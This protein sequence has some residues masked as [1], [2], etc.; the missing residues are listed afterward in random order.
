[1]LAICPRRSAI[2]VSVKS[3]LG[4]AQSN[5]LRRTNTIKS[6]TYNQLGRSQHPKFIRRSAV[7][8]YS[9]GLG[10]PRRGMLQKR[11]CKPEQVV[12]TE[13]AR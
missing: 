9:A 6:N 13:P 1:V 2:S 7:G 4:K 11:R 12:V 10:V 5:T 8:I 3:E